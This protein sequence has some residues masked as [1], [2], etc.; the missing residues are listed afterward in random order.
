MHNDEP[1][2][3]VQVVVRNG[4]HFL[5]ACL[6]AVRAQTYHN[7][8]VVVLDNDSTDATA[9]IV[10][11]EY[12]EF[13]LIRS[14]KNLGMWP[15]H[16][17]L[18]PQT[19]GPYVLGLS[20]DVVLDA[21]FIERCVAACERDASIAAVQGK[22]Y[23]L[24]DTNRIDTCGFSLTRGRTVVNIGHGELDGP[25]YTRTRIILG[26]EG[27]APFFRRSA[28]E[29]CAIEGHIWD[30]DYFWYG[31]DFD[32]AWRMTLLGHRQIFLPDAHAWHDRSTTKGT[33]HT[34]II[35]QLRRLHAR[36]AIPLFKRRLDWSNTRFTIIKNDSIIDILRDA[37]WILARELMILGYT[38]LFEPGVLREYGRFFRLLPRML[39]RRRLIMRRIHQ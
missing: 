28:L 23:Q 37:P 3:S 30:P 12:P 29:D 4:E 24:P 1:L 2:V 20:V 14:E 19:R 10:Q 6:H 13:R 35:G 36:R 17:S 8:E 9:H 18:L 38:I 39:R 27:A 32:L 15:G 31:D 11:S 33:A 16:E 34:P 22:T 21:Q 25:A 7:L 26:V 5:R